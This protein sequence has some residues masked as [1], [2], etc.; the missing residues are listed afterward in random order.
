VTVFNSRHPLERF[1]MRRRIDIII[2][3]ERVS[4]PPRERVA[5]NVRAIP[6]RGGVP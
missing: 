4:A 5:A 6:R 3:D 1:D 2:T